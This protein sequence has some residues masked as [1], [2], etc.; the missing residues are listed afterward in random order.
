VSMRIL[1]LRRNLALHVLGFSNR[2]KA[3]EV[4][5]LM[6]Y[7]V[8][9]VCG[10]GKSTVG[11]L[12]AGRLGLAFYDGDDFHPEANVEKMSSGQALNDEDRKPWLL[13]LGKEISDW[14]GGGGA[15]LACSAL[16]RKYRNWLRR[17]NDGDVYFVYLHGSRELLAGRLGARKGHFMDPKLLDSQLE[18][19]EV[20]EEDLQVSIDNS[21]EGIVAAIM[22]EL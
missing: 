3:A 9:G 8:M 21:P 15:V 18:T 11:R 2:R 6:V 4:F 12:L 5:L 22:K 20:P 14:N 19:L 17:G 7:V 1:L 16:R 13:S 10:C